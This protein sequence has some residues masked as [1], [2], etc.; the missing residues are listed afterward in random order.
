M[1]FKKLTIRIGLWS[2]CILTFVPIIFL[3][4]YKTNI[5]TLRD[6]KSMDINFLILSLVF[7]CLSWCFD[8]FRLKVLTEIN[9]TKISFVYG[10]KA[11]LSYT[12]LANITPSSMG[13]GPLLIYMLKQKGVTYGKATAITFMRGAISMMFFA[14]GGIVIVR[15]NNE[16]LSNTGIKVLYD[17][18]AI[19]LAATGIFFFCLY[20]APFP[21]RKYVNSLFNYLETLSV[22][23]GRISR[24]KKGLFHVI[25]DFNS[26]IKGFI[27]GSSW[28]LILVVFYTA[29][30]IA[31]QF[32]AAPLILKGLG[33]DTRIMETF[34][35]QW[36][37]NFMLYCVPTPGGSGISEGL[38]YAFFSPLVPSHIIGIFLLLWK[39]VT[40]YVWILV[41]GL[42]VV[43]SIGMKRLEDITIN[44]EDIQ[45]H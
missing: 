34:M 5:N 37:L 45:L 20:F 41:G 22:L 15:F 36:V 33:L 6:F 42:I 31:S 9:S 30:I 27:L 28:R 32:L 16:L 12:F 2:F 21:T 3:I 24:I 14:I 39:F 7:L 40:T 10:I 17:Y 29:M 25:D 8:V 43:Y 26:S 11:I 35:I 13:G 19:I 23:R 38:G 44:G 4:V 18:T 1:A